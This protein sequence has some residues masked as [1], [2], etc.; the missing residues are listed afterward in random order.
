MW[1]VIS[2]PDM[3]VF[4]DVSFEE[5]LRRKKLNWTEAE[6]REQQRRLQHARQNAQFY[7]MT[8]GLTPA[9]VADAVAAF[10]ERQAG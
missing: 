3:L 4:L 1:Q 8:D 2:K 9:Q 7:L 10:L 5:S 6:Y